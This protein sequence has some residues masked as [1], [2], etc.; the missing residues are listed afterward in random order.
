MELEIERIVDAHAHFWD[1]ARAE[2]YPTLQQGQAYAR[3]FEEAT[4]FAES[5]KWNVEKVI[6]VAA[7][8]D[9]VAETLDLELRAKVTGQPVAIVGGVALVDPAQAVSQLD[10][11]MAAS[12]FRGVRPMGGNMERAIPSTD[13]LRA[14]KERNL[15][16]DIMA[17]PDKL[18]EA[19]RDLE[20][21]GDLTVVIEHTG[22]PRSDSD[23]EFELWKSGMSALATLGPN[24]HCKLSGLA[25]PFDTMKAES[26]KRWINHCLELFGTERCFFASNFPVDGV[27]GTFDELYTTYSSL[28]ADLGADERERLFA[29]NAEGVYRC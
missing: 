25:M 17:H 18:E 23:E 19:A 2:R 29:T 27:A 26:F 3:Y 14:L 5:S 10:R 22:W 7:S 1:P 4:Y 15:V 13:I 16:F 11:Q 21:W 20:G 28:T 12:R 24:I 8:R 9:F 6:H